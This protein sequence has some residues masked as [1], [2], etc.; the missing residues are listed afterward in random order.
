M[1]GVT[2]YQE[3]HKIRNLQNFFLPSMV[4]GKKSKFSILH[5]AQHTTQW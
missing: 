3:Q 4:G 5:H 1:E 2:A